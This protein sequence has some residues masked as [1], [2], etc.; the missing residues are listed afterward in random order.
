MY[1]RSLTQKAIQNIHD[2]NLLRRAQNDLILNRNS[3]GF[4]N[5]KSP[6][7]LP[8]STNFL[9]TRQASSR[10]NSKDESDDLDQGPVRYST[11]KAAKFRAAENFRVVD[12][13]YPPSQR[14]VINISLIVFMIYFFVLREENDL[15]E[16]LSKSLFDRFPHMEK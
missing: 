5:E 6:L 3:S 8:S 1:L 2:L 15:D 13:K 7:T 4:M 9:V 10:L 11:S 14:W 16:E 12:D